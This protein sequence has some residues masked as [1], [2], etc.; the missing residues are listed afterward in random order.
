MLG[1]LDNDLSCERE[2][3]R[4]AWRAGIVAPPPYDWWAGVGKIVTLIFWGSVLVG[5]V[6][7][8]IDWLTR[9]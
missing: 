3:I 2:R 8:I 9:R 7:Q 6:I 1:D 4:E 5:S